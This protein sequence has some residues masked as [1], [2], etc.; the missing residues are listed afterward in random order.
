MVFYLTTP[1]RSQEVTQSTDAV[2]VPHPPRQAVRR[3]VAW[4]LPLAL[5]CALS[6]AYLIPLLTANAQPQGGDWSLPVTPIQAHVFGNTGVFLWTDEL[7]GLLGYRQPYM[8]DTPF[9]LLYATLTDIGIS[10]LLLTKILVLLIFTTAGY[11][12]YCYCKYL[13]FSAIGSLMSGLVPLFSPV[14]FNYLVMGWLFV[15]LTVA[16]LPLSL[17]LV[18]RGIMTGRIGYSLGGGLCAIVAIQS[19]ALIWYPLCWLLLAAVLYARGQSMWKAAASIVA[20]S[21]ILVLGDLSW[22][23]LAILKRSIVDQGASSTNVPLGQWLSALNILRLWGSLY[24][25]PYELSYPSGLRFTTVLLPLCAMIPL[26]LRYRD[27]RTQYHFLLAAI[28]ITAWYLSPYY[29]HLPFT[30]VVRDPSRFLSIAVVGYSVLI[31]LSFDSLCVELK[32][33]MSGKRILRQLIA[34]ALPTAAIISLTIPYYDGA[35]YGHATAGRDIRIRTLQFGPGTLATEQWLSHLPTGDKAIYIPFGGVVGSTTDGRFRGDYHEFNDPFAALS[36]IPG[37]LSMNNRSSG[38]ANERL[39][40]LL[41]S[42]GDGFSATKFARL[43]G[44]A[45]IKYVVVRSNLYSHAN[46][47]DGLAIASALRSSSFFREVFADGESIVFENRLALPRVYLVPGGE[48]RTLRRR[49]SDIAPRSSTFGQPERTAK[50]PQV[51]SYQE[52]SPVEYSV[53]ITG[54]QGPFVLALSESFDAG[55]KAYPVQDT[56]TRPISAI[57]PNGEIKLDVSAIRYLA[58]PSLPGQDHF[59]LDGFANAWLVR[60]TAGETSLHFALFYQPQAIY[61]LGQLIAWLSILGALGGLLAS[62]KA[63]L[64]KRHH[65]GC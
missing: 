33:R 15:L 35:L 54:I 32:C 63:D 26:A 16:L 22:L 21:S 14:F 38:A 18:H 25:E 44:D 34:A 20:A 62:A 57:N 65:G 13:G 17:L 3:M 7:G 9:R 31:A 40:S 19:Q 53:S 37:D 46:F 55:W 23:P 8:T 24:N 27:W 47:P 11:S 56:V 51:L 12:T 60:P 1:S 30:A 41:Q 50:E 2:G 10:P 59:K 36:P 39:M 29:G 4:G 6:A 49:A 5:Y 52:L 43:L 61:L 28:P 42:L 58:M 64:G 45:S 48:E